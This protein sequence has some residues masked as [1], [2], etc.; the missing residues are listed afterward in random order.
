MRLMGE[1][2]IAALAPDLSVFEAAKA[3]VTSPHW[4]HLVYSDTY[5]WG[6]YQGSASVPYKI[7]IA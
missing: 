6:Q 4:L 3:L 2:E 5:L 1:S 7:I